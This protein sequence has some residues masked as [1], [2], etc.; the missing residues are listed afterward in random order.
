MDNGVLESILAST[1]D[2]RVFSPFTGRGETIPSMG[3][4]Y[5]A[6]AQEGPLSHDYAQRIVSQ[7]AEAVQAGDDM[8]RQIPEPQVLYPQY[9]ELSGYLDYR[10]N[11]PMPDEQLISSFRPDESFLPL[12]P[13]Y[14]ARSR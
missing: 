14:Q 3:S 9:P 4:N 1:Q 8:M 11:F 12:N 2:R 5:V 6:R 10:P 7:G 13:P